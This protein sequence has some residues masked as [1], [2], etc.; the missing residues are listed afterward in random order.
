M[1]DSSSGREF[2]TCGKSP[3]FGRVDV[4]LV[5]FA[6]AILLSEPRRPVGTIAAGPEAAGVAGIELIAVSVLRNKWI[7]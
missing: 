2:D 3:A 4:M 6:A 5:A 7:A 1:W